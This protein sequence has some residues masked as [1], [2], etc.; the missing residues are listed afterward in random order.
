M[1]AAL[2]HYYFYMPTPSQTPKSYDELFMENQRLKAVG[3]VGQK[4]TIFVVSTII[5][6][7]LVAA[8]VV[9]ITVVRPDKDN[10]SLILSI[11]GVIV[12]VITALLAATIQQVHLAVNSRLSQLLELTATAS[13]AEGKIAAERPPI[14]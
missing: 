6:C 9:V 3:P 2:Q 14:K 7:I 11:V 5:L 4:T 8:F 1:T 13:R 10:T 12:P